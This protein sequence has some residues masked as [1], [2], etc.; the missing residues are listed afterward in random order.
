MLLLVK[1]FELLPNWSFEEASNNSRHI[2]IIVSFEY[3]PFDKWISRFKTS[4]SLL[5]SITPLVLSLSFWIK[6]WFMDSSTQ[7]HAEPI[8]NYLKKSALEPKRAKL[9]Q[10]LSFGHVRTYCWLNKLRNTQGNIY[11][12]YLGNIYIYIYICIYIYGTY[13]E[14]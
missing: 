7:N 5:S 12:T 10:R 6:R 2:L 1:I 11:G 4:C 14:Y 13:K 9:E 3:L 8:W